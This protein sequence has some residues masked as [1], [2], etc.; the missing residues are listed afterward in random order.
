M[1]T[2]DPLQINPSQY[3]A[4][5]PLQFSDPLGLKTACT[6][7]QLMTIDQAIKDTFDGSSSPEPLGTLPLLP[8]TGQSRPGL[9]ISTVPTRP[10]KLKLRSPVADRHSNVVVI[11]NRLF[12]A[13]TTAANRGDAAVNAARGILARIDTELSRANRDRDSALADRATCNVANAVA[14]A[15]DSLESADRA[16]QVARTIP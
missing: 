4:E 6:A 13:V 11:V 15:A 14:V 7:E 8:L 5:N 3:A 12:D 2:L 9:P 1:P 16:N 10:S